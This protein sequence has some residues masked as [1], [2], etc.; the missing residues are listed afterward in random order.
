VDPPPWGTFTCR[1]P[2]AAATRPA[3]DARAAGAQVVIALTD[4][5]TTSVATSG[6]RLGG[7]PDFAK[8]TSG[9]DVVFGYQGATP[10]ATQIGDAFVVEN[11]SRGLTY[12]RVSIVVTNGAVSGVTATIVQPDKANVTPDPAADTL[13]SPYRTQLAAAYDTK[14]T[15]STG[16]FPRDGTVERTSEVAIGDLIADALLAKYKPIGAQMAVMHAGGIR[17][18]IPSS[19]APADKTLRRNA[20][21]Y[22]SGPP[23]DVV[24]GDVYTVLPFGDLAVVESVKGSDIW[25][26]LENAV[27]IYPTSATRFLQISGFTF[28]FSASGAPNAR[29]QSVTLD[30]GTAVKKDATTYVLV[31][32]DIEA[33]GG[34]GYAMLVQSPLPAGRDVM[35]DVMVEYM[36]TKA[37]FDPTPAK[38]ITILP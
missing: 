30:D 32:P 3:H 4:F 26:A 7:L 28:S 11:E 27:S 14:V 2:P 23:Y 29:V 22:A 19:Y 12:A 33:A 36:K 9:I 34:D 5:E 21:G 13:L 17:A 18:P 10:A 24:V 6:E 35:A 20:A 38:R 1:A 37:S 25:A 16:V 31:L 15:T 8:G